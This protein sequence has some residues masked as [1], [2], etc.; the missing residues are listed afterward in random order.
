ML[1]IENIEFSYPE[2]TQAFCFNL[3]LK[4][5]KTAL[6]SGISG[7]GKSTFLDLIAG[8][9]QPKK[10][11]I[12]LDNFDIIALK[13]QHR[14]VSIL[15]QSDNL[16]EHLSV[17]RNLALA[18][19]I[20]VSNIILNEKIKQSL[21]EVG[22]Q[23]FIDKKAAFLSGGQKQRV[24][25]AR[26]LL[27]NRQILLLDEPFSALDEAAANAMREL[28]KKLIKK[29]NWHTIIVSHNLADIKKL[30]ASHYVLANNQIIK[31]EN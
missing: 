30:N 19:P 11:S 22:L 20:K 29:Y 2:Q 9:L 5:G 21:A 18:L 4:A 25:L 14:P 27:L 6:I 15:L 24:A 8:F 31:T 23:D 1:K 16:F 10:G 28:L 3:E 13:A 12:I 17:R 7:A 26:T